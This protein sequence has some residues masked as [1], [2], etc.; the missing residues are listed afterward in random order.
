MQNLKWL[1][2]Y[3][4]LLRIICLTLYVIT[5]EHLCPQEE[6]EEEY[7]PQKDRNVLFFYFQVINRKSNTLGLIIQKKHNFS[8]FQWVR[9]PGCNSL[10]AV[11]TR[12]D[13]ARFRL[14]SV[15]YRC[16]WMCIQQPK[17]PRIHSHIYFSFHSF[18][19]LFSLFI[20][21]ECI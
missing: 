10:F 1:I 7:I 15:L 17:K 19:Q 11:A 14:I 8:V 5:T 12:N 4:N 20:S 3:F 13:E 6:T 2:F 21:Q 16:H 9:F 18:A